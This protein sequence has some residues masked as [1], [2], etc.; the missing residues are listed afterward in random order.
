ME[1]KFWKI[2]DKITYWLPIIMLYGLVIY[3]II[4]GLNYLL[5]LIFI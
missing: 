5:N 1:T 3:L 2:T 4:K